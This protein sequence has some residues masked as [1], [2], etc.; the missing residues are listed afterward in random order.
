MNQVDVLTWFSNCLKSVQCQQSRRT[1]S[2]ARFCEKICVVCMYIHYLCSETRQSY[3]QYLSFFLLR[4][5][6]RWSCL[7]LALFS[8][9]SPPGEILFWHISAQQKW[10]VWGITSLPWSFCAWSQWQTLFPRTGALP[11]KSEENPVWMMHP[12][13]F[14]ATA[15]KTMEWC[16]SLKTL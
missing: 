7:A 5:L 12:Q 16:I 1:S 13:R 4:N 15:G 2:A 8:L 11:Q 14:V 9:C 3:K 6:N 10:T